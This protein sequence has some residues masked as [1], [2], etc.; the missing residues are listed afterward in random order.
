MMQCTLYAK[1]L[2]VLQ[3][4][5]E[6]Y[7]G[8]PAPGATPLPMPMLYPVL[9]LIQVDMNTLDC[10]NYSQVCVRA[11]RNYES[12]TCNCNIYTQCRAV[13]I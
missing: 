9:Q 5:L 10:N 1:K 6:N 12:H 8:A 7:G 3:V 13:R 4:Q 11:S 2:I